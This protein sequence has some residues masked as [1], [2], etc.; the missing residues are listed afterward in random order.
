LTAGTLRLTTFTRNMGVVLVGS[1]ATA[2]W[3]LV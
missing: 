2:V 1:I 3:E